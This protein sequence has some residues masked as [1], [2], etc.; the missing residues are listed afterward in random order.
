[1]KKHNFLHRGIAWVKHELEVTLAVLILLA[2]VVGYTFAGTEAVSN[3]Q[4]TAQETATATSS[5]SIG[6]GSYNTLSFAS[7]ITG[8]G[9]YRVRKLNVTPSSVATTATNGLMGTTSGKYTATINLAN[10]FSGAAYVLGNSTGAMLNGIS[11]TSPNSPVVLTSVSSLV[12]EFEGIKNT[13]QGIS[14]NPPSSNV[15]STEEIAT[16]SLLPT[17]ATTAVG[18]ARTFAVIA[19]D[20][21]GTAISADKLTLKWSLNTTPTGIATVNSGG[22]VST[23]GAGT[24]TVK[25]TAGLRSASATITVVEPKET[26]VTTVTTP[27]NTADKTTTDTVANNGAQ[28]MLNKISKVLTG[29]PAEAATLSTSTTIEAKSVIAQA[30]AIA[31]AAYSPAVIAERFTK[32]GST[33]A[34]QNEIKALVAT[35]PTTT[36]KIATRFNL[37]INEIKQSFIEMAVGNKTVN[38]PSAIKTLGNLISGLF[39]NAKSSSAA[40]DNIMRNR[41]TGGSEEGEY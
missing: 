38:K 24:V 18:T 11:I 20:A 15:I 36:G 33:I 10:Q 6:S 26:P 8:E 4:L 40:T 16:L 28:P 14:I 19:I 9:V 25:V 12:L 2:A 13:I 34:K 21:D 41:G 3:N 35:Q 5:L 32:T 37:A 1:M 30:T 31:N 23:T 39:I 7:S 17:T 29:S 27:S 22:V